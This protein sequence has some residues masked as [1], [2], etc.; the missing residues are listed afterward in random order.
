MLRVL[1]LYALLLSGLVLTGCSSKPDSLSAK[2]SKQFSSAD[3]ETKAL[4]SVVVSATKTNGYLQAMVALQGLRARDLTPDQ[5][6][7]VYDTLTSL[8]AQLVA[9]AEKG[10]PVAKQTLSDLRQSQRR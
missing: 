4:W 2:Y 7:A 3:P 9:K 10:D 1:S 8:N 5:D 6:K